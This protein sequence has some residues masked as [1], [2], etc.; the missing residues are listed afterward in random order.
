MSTGKGLQTLRTFVVP[1]FS[2]SGRQRKVVLLGPLDTK[3]ELFF[4]SHYVVTQ[5][6]WIF[7]SSSYFV[8][9]L[10][11]KTHIFKLT[12]AQRKSDHFVLV[13]RV[14]MSEITR[15]FPHMP[16]CHVQGRLYLLPS[17]WILRHLVVISGRVSVRR[18]IHA[19]DTTRHNC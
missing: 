5:K 18:K 11:F 10:I 16:S 6:A 19:R 12:T 1:S 8:S 14:R 15:T 13:S 9:S 4:I 3:F 2:Q 17:E 7:K